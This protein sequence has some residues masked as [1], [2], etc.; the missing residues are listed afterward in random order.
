MNTNAGFNSAQCKTISFVSIGT[1]SVKWDVFATF[2]FV[3]TSDNFTD[4]FTSTT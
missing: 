4:L 1:L 2:H 3:V